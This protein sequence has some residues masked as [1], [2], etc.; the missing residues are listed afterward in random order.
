[1]LNLPQNF[2]NAHVR[3]GVPGAIVARKQQLQFFAGLPRSASAQHPLQSCGF[4]QT[5]DPGFEQKVSHAP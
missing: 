2:V 4:N 5:A 1:M 3:S